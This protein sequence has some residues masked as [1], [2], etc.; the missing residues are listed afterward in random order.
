MAGLP[1]LATPLYLLAFLCFPRRDTTRTPQARR[2][3]TSASPASRPRHPT[4]PTRHPSRRDPRRTT[5]RR[6]RGSMVLRQHGYRP[7]RGSDC[8]PYFSGN[9]EAIRD[10]PGSLHKEIYASGSSRLWP[11]AGLEMLTASSAV[12][13]FV[14]SAASRERSASPRYP[15]GVRPRI[16][17][18]RALNDPKAKRRLP[19]CHGDFFDPPATPATGPHS[20]LSLGDVGAEAFVFFAHKV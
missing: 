19:T 11:P 18:T 3:N 5:S 9:T 6:P 13:R 8:D 2:A 15:D 10:S 7:R 20:P 17:A 12:L 1:L 16:Y 4:S 14:R